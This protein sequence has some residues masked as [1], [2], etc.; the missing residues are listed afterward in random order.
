ML[1]IKSR[2][3]CDR[4][5]PCSTC[6]TRGLALSCSYPNSHHAVSQD[7]TARITRP[8]GSVQ[9][10]IVQL[11]SLVES[12]IPKTA[13]VE[14]QQQQQQQQDAI[15][16]ESDTP[17]SINTPENEEHTAPSTPSEYGSMMSCRTGVKYVGSTH[18]VAVLDGI[19]ELKDHFQQEADVVPQD[20]MPQSPP[21]PY[22]S[23]PHLLYGTTK[24]ATKDEVL[25]S[26]PPRSIVDRFISRYFN[27]M[28]LSSSQFNL[29]CTMKNF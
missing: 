7:G 10:R 18:W 14:Q 20:I 9:D 12:L 25:A 4:K 21:P 27:I 17:T 8:K 15:T 29:P 28:D 3:K 16:I 23:I 26:M 2:L 24:A 6:S 11:E 19:S 1:L 22:E 13:T 5:H